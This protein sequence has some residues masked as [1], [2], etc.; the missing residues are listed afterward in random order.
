MKKVTF[1]KKDGCNHVL[2]VIQLHQKPNFL[3]L[4]AE[5]NSIF[6][7]KYHTENPLKSW[8]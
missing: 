1:P 6:V 7:K 4:F 8:L 5:M 2:C 3:G